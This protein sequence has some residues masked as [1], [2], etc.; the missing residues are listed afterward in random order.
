M[1][2]TLLTKIFFFCFFLFLLSTG[3]A[4]AQ[5]CVSGINIHWEDVSCPGEKDGTATITVT[6]GTPDFGYILQKRV[7]GVTFT[8][9]AISDGPQGRTYT[10][11]GVEPGSYRFQIYDGN[12]DCAGIN[13]DNF[14]IGTAGTTPAAITITGSTAVCEGEEGVVYEVPLTAGSSYSWTVPSGATIVSGATGPENNKIEV[15]FASASGEVKVV[16]TNEGGCPGP[17]ASLAVNV[18]AKPQVF[19]LSN[20]GSL[21][22]CKGEPGPEIF[23]DGSESGMSYSL[24]RDNVTLVDTKEG[25]GAVLS[26]GNQNIEGSYTVQAYV[27]EL[28]SCRQEMAGELSIVVNTIPVAPTVVGTIAPVCQNEDAPAITLEGQEGATIYIYADAALTQEVGTGTSFDPDGD[29]NFSSTT[30]ATFT[31]YATQELNGCT[32]EARPFDVVVLDKPEARFEVDAVEVCEGDAASLLVILQGTQPF[33]LTYRVDGGQEQTVT[34]INSDQ[35]EILL[36]K[37]DTDV[38]VE[39]LNV[40]DASCTQE[41]LSVTATVTVN[42]RPVAEITDF[43]SVCVEDPAFELNN[44]SPAGGVYSGP[45]VEFAG[46]VYTFSPELAGV[47]THTISYTVTNT[48]TGCD[49]TVQASIT[50]NPLPVVELPAFEDICVNAREP[51]LLNSGTPAGGVYSGTGVFEEGGVY[52]FDPEISGVGTFSINYTYAD[53]NGCENSAQQNITVNSAVPPSNLVVEISEGAQEL[54]AGEEVTLSASADNAG[55]GAVYRWFKN[56]DIN[57]LQEGTSNIFTFK[58]VDGDF[59]KLEL[60]Q[61]S[62]NCGTGETITAQTEIFQVNELPT[63]TLPEDVEICQGAEETLNF[64]FTGIAPFTLVYSASTAVGE[65]SITVNEY[66][67][68]LTVS[69]VETTTYTF[70][71][72]EDQNCIQNLV[73]QEVTVTVNEELAP[74]V[75]IVPAVAEI[76][77]GEDVLFSAN[78]GNGGDNPGY[79]WYIDGVLSGT[80]ETLALENIQANASVYLELTQ[81]T[82]KCGTGASVTSNT[83]N[84]D[85][86]QKVDAS[87]SGPAEVCLADVPVSY[88][89]KTAGGTFTA[90]LHG[91]VVADIITADG[92][93]TP[94]QA[95]TYTIIYSITSERG[96]KSE[97]NPLSVT[98]NEVQ[99][100]SL[101]LDQEQLSDAV[102]AGDNSFRFTANITNGGENPE[103]KWFVN[104]VLQENE[105]ATEFTV[106]N[107]P[108]GTNSVSVEVKQGAA[109]GTLICGNGATKAEFV[110][111][112]IHKVPKAV[113]ESATITICEGEGVPLRFT[114]TGTAPFSIRYSE[115]SA[116]VETVYTQENIQDN[117]LIVSVFPSSSAS[118]KPVGF[119]D[120]TGCNTSFEGEVEVIISDA[121]P[122][123]P[124]VTQAEFSICE[125]SGDYPSFSATGSNLKWYLGSVAEGNLVAENVDSYTPTVTDAGTYTYYVTQTNNCGTSEA[126]TISFIIR[127]TEE[128]AVDPACE[129]APVVALGDDITRCA[130]AEVTLDSGYEPGEAYSVE[131]TKDGEPIEGARTITVSTSGLYAVVVTD[132]ATSCFATDEVQVTIEEEIISSVSIEALN[133]ITCDNEPLVLDAILING[134]EAPVYYW[135]H[136]GIELAET[137][138][139]LTLAEFNHADEIRLVVDVDLNCVSSN[140]EAT[141]II[142]ETASPTAT[143]ADA[144]KTICKGEEVLLNFTFTG[145]APFSMVYTDGTSEFALEN[146]EETQYALSVRPEADASYSLLSFADASGCEASSISGLVTVKVNPLPTATLSGDETICKGDEATLSFTFTGKAPFIVTYVEENS[147]GELTYTR[148][149][150]RT[151]SFETTVSPS[152]TASYTILSIEDANCSQ[153]VTDQALTV[154]VIEKL[155]PEVSGT[156]FSIC[157][158]EENPSFNATGSNLKWYL[159]SVAEGNLVAENVDSYTP[160]VTDVGT[161]A[162]YVTQTNNCG[163]SEAAEISFTI[164][165]AEECAVDPNCENAPV[166]ALGDDINRCAPAE[167]TLDAGYDPGAEYSVQWK[168]NGVNID[169]GRTI[170]VNSSGTYAVTVTNLASNC[171]GTDEVN[172]NIEESIT[173]TVA[174]E[175]RSEVNC[176][177]PLQLEAVLTNGGAS[178]VYS[179]YYN[180]ELLVG[181]NS[182]TISLT[183]FADDA[184]V[185]V[186]VD[187]DLEC[188]T[189]NPVVETYLISLPPVPA[190]PVVTTSADW[191]CEEGAN[192]VFS[193]EE[194]AEPVRWYK[195]SVAPENLVAESTSYTSTETVAGVYTYYATRSNVCGEG[196]ATALSFTI[197]SA[198]EC[199][200]DPGCEI[201]P[202]AEI[203]ILPGSVL[204]EDITTV[205]LEA[206]TQDLG[207]NAQYTWY[208]N[209]NEIGTG[210]ATNYTAEGGFV[211]GDEFRLQVKITDPAYICNGVD[212]LEDFLGIT[213]ESEIQ[214]TAS[215][216]PVD[217]VCLESEGSI[218]LIPSG[219]YIDWRDEGL[220]T[221]Y[222]WYVDGA[223]RQQVTLEPTHEIEMSYFMLNI[224]EI[225]E[226]TTVELQINLDESIGCILD[227]ERVSYTIPVGACG[228]EGIS[229]GVFTA[230]L[231]EVVSPS[232]DEENGALTYEITGGAAPYFIRYTF[233]NERVEQSLSGDP[234]RVDIRE[235]PASTTVRLYIRDANGNECT[236]ENELEMAPRIAVTFTK[237]EGGDVS[238]FGEEIGKA[239]LEVTGGNA[240][241]QYLLT[242]EEGWVTLNGRVKDFDNLPAGVNNILVRDSE[243][244]HCPATAT[245]EILSLNPKLEISNFETER[246]NCNDNTG[247][248]WIHEITGGNGGPYKLKLQTEASFRDY[249]P[250]VAFENLARGVYTVVVSDGVCEIQ[251]EIR[252]GSPGLIAVDYSILP[253]SCEA[254]DLK[255]GLYAKINVD[256][257]EVEG[258]YEAAIARKNAAGEYEVVTGMESVRFNGQN[259]LYQYGLE[260][261]TYSIEVRTVNREG[262]PEN[263][264]NIVVN[265]AEMPAPITFRHTPEHIYCADAIGGVQIT[266]L[267]G[268]MNVPYKISIYLE[269]ELFTER[270]ITRNEYAVNGGAAGVFEVTGLQAGVYRMLISQEQGGCEGLETSEPVVFRVEENAS[271]LSAEVLSK[272]ESFPERGSAM[273]TL[274]VESNSG[275][276][277]YLSSIYLV[278]PL[279]PG[280]FYES[281]ADEVLYDPIEATYQLTYNDLPAGKYQIYVTDENGCSVLLEEVIEHDK[282]LFIPNVFT[283]NGDGYNEYFYVRN[284]PPSG[285]RL[286]ITNRWGKVIFSTDNYV[287]DWDG[288]DQPDGVYFYHLQVIGEESID[289][290]GWLE[291]RR[292]GTP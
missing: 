278:E 66:T 72:I 223:L 127:T 251:E 11:E 104:D 13:S 147:K 231:L 20:N 135:Y 51:L 146:I 7:F 239:R 91:E 52:K 253:F 207:E 45:G 110:S 261:G 213:V 175:E 272:T 2:R 118:Y 78:V 265:E 90:M 84:I 73:D 65:T 125:G 55:D 6:G 88:T 268:E 105:T 174:I 229:C 37:P 71:S 41:N 184:I 87:F 26:F 289:M 242:E 167:V 273:L 212:E 4:K 40:S 49:T 220:S 259:E 83:V 54:C 282:R 121:A 228:G 120:A 172:V 204:C 102:C 257:T 75:D 244:D 156:E 206:E 109:N 267:N 198:Q 28:N 101:T 108:A 80:G 98:V 22:F 18:L 92:S 29:P 286:T 150:V 12:M 169:G 271:K 201:T 224:S 179:W 123:A 153:E 214:A 9:Y 232:C 46:G 241:F 89:P 279:F 155:V 96:C 100:L 234:V 245:V 103:I 270:T 112:I 30:A 263:I 94:T 290:K 199:A 5:D 194:G 221:V 139:R 1:E 99:T 129:N 230:S 114:L 117:E 16:E 190:A 97:S 196:E 258:P 226:N 79:A 266:R 275:Q 70:L 287:N 128:C 47:E 36:G 44:G 183:E 60:S 144:T 21:T 85:V 164:R 62:L 131:W 42:P 177:G 15:N 210:R 86:E 191:V 163:E 162:Y 56:D 227:P 181:E 152:G 256:L 187:V 17:E 95:G 168:H 126:A 142:S 81:G 209:G 281:E 34:D 216:E 50:V 111:V 269:E 280:Q 113:L 203:N 277:P 236:L 250:E 218:T 233:N 205:D 237:A 39:L 106:S 274:S 143:L 74:T 69:P 64:T 59:I 159:G 53:V 185:E 61:G 119:S 215:I 189:T 160:T 171:K 63:V 32:S 188:A 158:G 235:I 182:S 170:M 193:V 38:I 246:A 132:L 195:G 140:P 115:I 192:P 247:K 141:Y 10:F 260:N 254:P 145:Q 243:S 284:I 68:A 178:P 219:T 130:P 288:D 77:E 165:T 208:F 283:P 197:R 138:S 202:L 151:N 292:G 136:N 124:T 93:F 200:T 76:C 249:D 133:E 285:S 48:T 27:S 166:V 107:L 176:E 116:G 186:S 57:P 161:Y 262:C 148:R 58:P 23:L 122:A 149:T 238:C 211:D 248:I 264:K 154:T 291:I 67:L 14:I 137:G 240:P 24:Y 82:L 31:Y 217:P 19:N 252:V 173:A 43:E 180:G 33:T 35:Y 25:T 255:A 225:T 276:H 157:V 222:S 8:D 3:F 134:G